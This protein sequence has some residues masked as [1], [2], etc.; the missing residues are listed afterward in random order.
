MK[1]KIT[2]KFRQTL[3]IYRHFGRDSFDLDFSEAAA[4][5]MFV[6]ESLGR[7]KF[8]EHYKRDEIKKNNG[9]NYAK[10][11][12]DITVAL[13]HESWNETNP[14]MKIPLAISV[15]QLYRRDPITGFQFPKEFLDGIIPDSVKE[16]LGG[17]L[18][19]DPNWTATMDIL[20]AET[21]WESI[22]NSL[23]QIRERQLEWFRSSKGTI[24]K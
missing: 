21:D 3:E 24:V 1:I 9:Y 14:E 23:A 18:E 13:W 15:W 19:P 10:T 8:L 12:L 7:K 5:E 2:K 17:T 16:R 4:Q 22:R 6:W 20:E 11:M